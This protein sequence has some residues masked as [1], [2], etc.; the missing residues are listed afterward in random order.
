MSIPRSIVRARKLKLKELWRGNVHFDMCRKGYRIRQNELTKGARGI[1]NFLDFRVEEGLV[2]CTAPVFVRKVYVLN[3]SRFRSKS[4]RTHRA[5]VGDHDP[6]QVGR[7][8]R[9]S[10][11][12]GSRLV[13]QQ[14]LECAESFVTNATVNKNI[15][16]NEGFLSGNRGKRIRNKF[17]ILRWWD[18]SARFSCPKS[19]EINFRE[20]LSQL[21]VRD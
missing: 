2:H 13:L 6:R 21:L 8:E 7:A 11:R 1:A 14:L 19:I 10:V 5:L 20:V 3:S 9:V 15:R 4:R 18:T 17:N 16:A 12:T